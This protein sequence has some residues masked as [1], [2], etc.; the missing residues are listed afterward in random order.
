RAGRRHDVLRAA[1]VNVLKCV[2]ADLTDDADEVNHSL[3]SIQ[4]SFHRSSVENI[5]LMNFGM[6]ASRRFPNPA[7]FRIARQNAGGMPGVVK[8]V[9]QFLPDKA[10]RASNEDLHATIFAPS[11]LLR[12]DFLAERCS[13][14][15]KGGSFLEP[16]T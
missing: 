7:R 15:E 13:R 11:C 9:K 14:H 5:S 1:R 12:N 4:A 6:P 10:G 16:G 2:L 8:P 3:H